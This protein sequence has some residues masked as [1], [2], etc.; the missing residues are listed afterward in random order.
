MAKR[1]KKV[2][3]L[4]TAKAEVQVHFRGKRLE[5]TVSLP[6]NISRQLAKRLSKRVKKK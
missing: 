1:T 6:I 4:H 3:Y 2:P 5:L